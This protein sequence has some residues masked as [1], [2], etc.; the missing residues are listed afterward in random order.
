MES[1]ETPQA[2]FLQMNLKKK[3]RKKEKDEEKREQDSKYQR[4]IQKDG[5]R[6]NRNTGV[7]LGY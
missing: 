3:V 7:I 1:Q 6:Q 2:L 4:E 5:G